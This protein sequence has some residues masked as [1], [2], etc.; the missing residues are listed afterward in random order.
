ME[1]FVRLF[2]KPPSHIDGHYH[3][4]LCTNL[5]LSKP[6]PVRTRIRRNFSFRAGEKSP[7][8]RG[9]LALVDRWLARRYQVTDYFFKLTQCIEQNKLDRVVELARSSNVEFITHPI[10]NGEQEYLMSDEFRA[11][12]QHLEIDGYA[13]V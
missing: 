3:M 10:V 4:H 6:I 5:L 12:S 2:E 1:E 8:N 11:I 7:S 13:L 9:Y